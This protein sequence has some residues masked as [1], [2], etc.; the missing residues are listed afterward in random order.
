M[1]SWVLV[2]CWEVSNSRDAAALAPLPVPSPLVLVLC[3]SVQCMTRANSEE[4]GPGQHFATRSPVDAKIRGKSKAFIC[5]TVSKSI[6]LKMLLKCGVIGME[7]EQI[8]CNDTGKVTSGG[9]GSLVTHDAQ[10]PLLVPCFLLCFLGLNMLYCCPPE[11][12]ELPFAFEPRTYLLI[13]KL[14][15]TKHWNHFY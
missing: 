7:G 4:N 5:Y 11:F 10:K 15:V 8:V 6:Y 2:E 9:P 13:Q 12:L 14:G 3:G 1:G